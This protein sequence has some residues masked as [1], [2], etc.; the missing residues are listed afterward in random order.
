M[1]KFKGQLNQDLEHLISGM[2]FAQYHELGGQTVPLIID[3]DE[4]QK[5]Q[6]KAAEGT[7][8]GDLLLLVET[9]YLKSRPVE[10]K[11]LRL[12][13]KIYLVVSCKEKEGLYEIAIGANE[14]W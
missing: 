5:R 8:L 7:Y 10:G 13:G 1:D 4:L 2:E 12:D 6:M 14:S 9:R 3:E 11:T